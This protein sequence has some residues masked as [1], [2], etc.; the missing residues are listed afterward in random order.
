MQQHLLRVGKI[1]EGE[2]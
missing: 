1:E 2:N